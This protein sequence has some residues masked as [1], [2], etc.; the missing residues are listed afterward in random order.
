MAL[1]CTREESTV[2]V[3]G[4]LCDINEVH[5]YHPGAGK[6]NDIDTL[7]NVIGVGASEYNPRQDPID[8]QPEISQFTFYTA[9][10]LASGYIAMQCV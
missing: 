1:N 6:P 9:L 4:R 10:V 3:S 8:F 2:D 5:T 7:G